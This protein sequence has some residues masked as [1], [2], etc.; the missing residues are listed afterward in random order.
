MTVE[1]SQEVLSEREN[2]S[3]CCLC[4]PSALTDSKHHFRF[5]CGAKVHKER[6]VKN[7]AFK[8]WCYF[9]YTKSISTPQGT[10]PA[11]S[12]LAAGLWARRCGAVAR[13]KSP[14]P[15]GWSWPQ[16]CSSSAGGRALLASVGQGYRKGY[17]KQSRGTYQICY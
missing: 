5:S 15:A 9:V 6:T 2:L 14:C 10:L 12:C 17:R 16:S 3:S 13:R 4:G 7:G 8:R 11:S 1:F